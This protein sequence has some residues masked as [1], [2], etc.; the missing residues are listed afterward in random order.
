MDAELL[1]NVASN[2]RKRSTARTPEL[3][4]LAQVALRCH[5]GSLY[6]AI[7]STK[8]KIYWNPFILLSANMFDLSVR[9]GWPDYIS[10][11]IITLKIDDTRPGGIMKNFL[12]SQFGTQRYLEGKRGRGRRKARVITLLSVMDSWKSNPGNGILS[13]A[14]SRS[15]L[16]VLKLL[17]IPFSTNDTKSKPECTSWQQ[18]K[19][20]LPLYPAL[21]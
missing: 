11:A 2:L 10:S 6:E 14:S 4:R 20:H 16:L 19:C 8:R 1:E 9:H 13:E 12:H 15:S 7:P 21:A 18:A 17:L 5:N 3:K